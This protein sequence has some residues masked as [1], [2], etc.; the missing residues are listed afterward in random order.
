MPQIR[1][2][3][4]VLYAAAKAGKDVSALIAPPY[5][6]LDEISK[7]ALLRQDATNIVAVDLPHLPAKAV[8][9][10]ET[11]RKAGEQYRDW[12]SKGVLTR[13]D[14]PAVLLYQQ[15]YTVG[16]RTFKRRGIIA[17]VRV[18]DF[19]PAADGAGGVH[20][21]EQTFA[22]AKEDRLK[23]MRET[24]AQLSPIFG[25]Y[26]DPHSSIKSTLDRLIDSKPASFQGTTANDH[27]LHEAWIIDDHPT[28][29]QLVGL[30]H[31]VDIYIADGHHRY[32]TAL[33]YRKELEARQGSSLPANHPATGCLFVLVAMQDPGM[34][35]LPTHRVLGGMQD[36]SIDRLRAVAG[37][38][39]RIERFQGSSLAALEQA[40]PRAGHHA[41]GLYSPRD[42][43][44][45]MWI[46]TT[47][48]A[49]PLQAMFPSRSQA[50]RTLDVAIV[51]HLLVEQLVEPAFCGGQKVAW[52]FPHA[53]PEFESLSKQQSYQLG[54]MLQPTPLESVRL[55]SE[56]GELMPQKSTF[57]YPKLATGIV[58]NPLA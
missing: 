55:V 54:V 22:S 6:V 30:M 58:I 52:K 41:L 32:T 3:P 50:W 27:V 26:S 13:L 25:L 49:D 24:S 5:D 40:L 42:P 57:F 20:P 35:V 4:A 34:I 44:G 1:P 48:T 23:L 12:L 19:G 33:N 10:D 31:G 38:K 17:N 15:T 2:I 14:R 37:D 8:G 51:Q 46:A 29:A 47:P 56:A 45:D 11:Y 16:S 9:P 43:Q 7:P 28:I 39:L 53:L 21:H 18:Q 36:F